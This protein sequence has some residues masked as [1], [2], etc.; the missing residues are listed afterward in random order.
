V[1]VP[2]LLLGS[3][4]TLIDTSELQRDAFN[5]AFEQHGLTWRWEREEYADLLAGN[6]GADRISDYAAE[7]GE[8]VDV[9]AVHATKSQL[10]QEALR[11][12]EHT[13][14]AGVVETIRDAR[15]E[16]FKVALVTTTS[17]ENLD[18][19]AT[20]VAGTLAFDEVFDLVVDSSQVSTP[21][22]D[23]A[24]Y[25]HALD[26]LDESA[27]HAVA[28]EDNVGGVAAASAAGV[29]VVAFPNENT[30][31]HDFADA[32]GRVDELGL[33]AVRTLAGR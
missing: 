3:I 26:A 28:V 9:A 33:A 18:A 24:A 4:S 32:V 19:L 16:G 27:D 1:A 2:A 7:R 25:R 21:K 10:F 15:A 29:P 8:D 11:T 12:G 6:G 13:P 5:R 17:R 31:G 30:A 23:A 20:S 22:P 14:R